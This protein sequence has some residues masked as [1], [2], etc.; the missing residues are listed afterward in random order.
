MFQLIHLTSLIRQITLGWTWINE[1]SRRR[2]TTNEGVVWDSHTVGLN[3]LNQI[4]PM[5]WYVGINFFLLVYA[6]GQITR[7]SILIIS[8]VPRD[9]AIGPTTY[10]IIP[11]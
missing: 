9:N 11:C 6:F 5:S 8:P 3:F 10:H 7:Q 4:D 1:F 2:E